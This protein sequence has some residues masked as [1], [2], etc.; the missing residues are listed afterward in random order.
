MDAYIFRLY[1]GCSGTIF[2]S[3]YIDGNLCIERK[4]N[5]DYGINGEVLSDAGSC[6]SAA[7]HRRSIILYVSLVMIDKGIERK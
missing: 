1:P 5:K 4:W 6:M 3:G 2:P 7:Y